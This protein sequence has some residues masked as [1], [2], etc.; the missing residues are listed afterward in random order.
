MA[1]FKKNL[2][3]WI[4]F[5]SL[6]FLKINQRLISSVTG[7]N[8]VSHEPGS[9][10]YTI[11]LKL[12]PAN[13]EAS[14]SW[15]Y[16]SLPALKN[17]RGGLVFTQIKG[18]R[19]G[20]VRKPASR[21]QL[22]QCMAFVYWDSLKGPHWTS[23]P[24]PTHHSFPRNSFL[25]QKIHCGAY[26]R[27]HREEGGGACHLLGIL[28]TFSV[29]ILLKLCTSPRRSENRHSLVIDEEVELLRSSVTCLSLRFY[30]Q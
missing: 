22:G 10:S 21:N 16:G 13:S 12:S 9:D 1:V 28:Y 3:T 4:R 14:H 6:F 15:L 5:N 24:T 19:R 8:P 7:F 18:K 29:K 27:Q 2:L 20:G 11:S 23:T 26:R 17:R 30:W 25:L